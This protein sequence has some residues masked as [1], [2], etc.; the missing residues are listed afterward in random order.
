[1]AACHG[2]GAG[3]VAGPCLCYTA[4]MVESAMIL[5]AGLGTRLRP[6]TDER[7]KPLVE[8]LG[9]PLVCFSLEHARR[10]GARRVALNTHHLH[11]AIEEALGE[12][13]QG[14]ELV[15]SYEPVIL[16]TGGGA[17]QMRE[18]L[19]GLNGP[20][21]LLNADALL[22]V[23][24]A[25]MA[26]L[27]DERRPLATLALK[28]TADKRRYGVLGTDEEDRVRDFAGRNAKR[29]P[30]VRERMFCGVHVLEPAVLDALPEGFSGINDEGYPR[31]LDEGHTVVAF[32][33]P[34]YFCD[35]GT[36]ERLLEANLLLLSGAERLRHLD[37]FA[38]FP[39]TTTRTH[40]HERAQVASDATLVGPVLIDEGAVIESGARVGPLAV[41]GKGCRVERGAVVER[42]VLQSRAVARGEVRDGVL[43]PTCWMEVAPAVGAALAAAGG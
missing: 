28:D 37:P 22:D 29:G 11:P 31:L 20:A 39:T 25:A 13:Y 7:P 42:A 18:A 9:T 34:G 17:R 30:V 12:G 1:M 19:G 27:H 33:V 40:V 41:I 23:D 6:L 3:H 24:T 4:G 26:R 5:A 32:D 15:Y 16:G 35:V 2:A 10:A 14:L 38:R 43:A 8:V 21:L 36:P